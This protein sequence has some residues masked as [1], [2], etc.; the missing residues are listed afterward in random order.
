MLCAVALMFIVS[1]PVQ[2]Q[3]LG[4]TVRRAVATNPTVKSSSANCRPVNCKLDQAAT[5]RLMPQFSMT[6]SLQAQ[7]IDRPLGISTANNRMV[8]TQL[9]RLTLTGRPMAPISLIWQHCKM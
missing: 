6:A 7:N 8:P 5:G 9:F 3:T 1:A 4:D 2:A